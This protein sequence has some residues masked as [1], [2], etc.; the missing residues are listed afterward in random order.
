MSSVIKRHT[1]CA[2]L[3]FFFVN[4]LSITEI[5]CTYNVAYVSKIVTSSN[6]FILYFPQGKTLNTIVG[7]LRSKY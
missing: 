7:N 3:F 5:G 6:L 2:F 1:N 4:N